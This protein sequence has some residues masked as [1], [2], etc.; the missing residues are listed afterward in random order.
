MASPRR[1]TSRDCR[2]STGTCSR[3][4]TSGPA[5]QHTSDELAEL[6]GVSR[7][8][9]YRTVQRTTIQRTSVPPTAGGSTG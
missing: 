6:F 4:S 7:A 3:T 9:I 8:T 1:T 5:G 2:P